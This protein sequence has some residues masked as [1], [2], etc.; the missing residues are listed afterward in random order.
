MVMAC[1]HRRWWALA[2]VLVALNA[3]GLLWIRAGLL[4]DAAQA[5]TAA[6]GVRVQSAL[7]LRDVDAADRLTLV[8][9]R[10][11]VARDRICLL[12]TSPSPRDS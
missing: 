11:L 6:G 12:Y 3:A 5:R 4:A 2:V 8:F 10:G 1:S 7:P 9:D